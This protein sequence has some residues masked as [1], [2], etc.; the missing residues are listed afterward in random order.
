MG[1]TSIHGS[2]LER[3]VRVRQAACP[4]AQEP[5]SLF[6]TA[7]RVDSRV[8]ELALL[9]AGSCIKRNMQSHLFV[10]AGG[11]F[12]MF[13]SWLSRGTAQRLRKL[14]FTARAQDAMIFGPV[15][16]FRQGFITLHGKT[17]QQSG[18]D[19]Y[20]VLHQVMLTCLACD[21]LCCNEVGSLWSPFS[22]S[23]KA[24]NL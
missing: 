21:N 22:R 3:E 4:P 16:S 5:N 14:A 13:Q 19:R 18:F 8:C 9:H 23:S 10:E 6:N 15:F 11:Q 7:D 1:P 17:L 2:P 12:I 20:K 24:H